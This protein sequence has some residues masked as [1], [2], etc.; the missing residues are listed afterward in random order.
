ERR[1]KVSKAKERIAV[2]VNRKDVFAAPVPNAIQL[3]RNLHVREGITR[4]DGKKGTLNVRIE[5]LVEG[6]SGGKAWQAGLEL[7]YANEESF[8]V[9]PLRLLDQDDVP[10]AKAKRMEISEEAANVTIS[11]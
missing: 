10:V 1:A 9:R 7:D 2:S 11:L 6:V 3:W 4:D 8:G 5:L